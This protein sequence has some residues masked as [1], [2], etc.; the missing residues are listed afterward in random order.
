MRERGSLAQLDP[1]PR[2][3]RLTRAESEGD[4]QSGEES[5]ESGSVLHWL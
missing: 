2:N 1:Y 5:T 3:M 4:P